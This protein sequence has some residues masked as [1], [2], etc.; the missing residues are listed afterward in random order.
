MF[1]TSRYLYWSVKGADGGIFQLDLSLVRSGNCFSSTTAAVNIVHNITTI[2]VTSM[3]LNL[4]DSLLYFVVGTT[5]LS[6]ISLEEEEIVNYDHGAFNL[7]PRSIASYNEYLAVTVGEA[8]IILFAR[9]RSGKG[10]PVVAVT[11][12]NPN[13]MYMIR[14]EFQ[15]L[16]GVY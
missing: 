3:T 11:G 1:Y 5:N 14:E 15:P 16:P 2:G 13:H 7:D 12:T 4:E 10:Q 6:S 9:I 8:P